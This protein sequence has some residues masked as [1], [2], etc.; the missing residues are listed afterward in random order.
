MEKYIFPYYPNISPLVFGGSRE[1]S[2][3]KEFGCVKN[4]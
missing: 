3:K 4:Q 2:K 1:F